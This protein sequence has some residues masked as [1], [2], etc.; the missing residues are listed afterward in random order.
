VDRH[1]DPLPRTHAA[2]QSAVTL[3]R[4]SGIGCNS[5]RHECWLEWGHGYGMVCGYVDLG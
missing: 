2:K 4:V 1:G 3:L 5:V